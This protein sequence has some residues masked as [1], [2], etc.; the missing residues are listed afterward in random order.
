MPTSAPVSAAGVGE[1]HDHQRHREPVDAEGEEPR[2]GALVR[3]LGADHLEHVRLPVA[4]RALGVAAQVARGPAE[5]LAGVGEQRLPGGERR[6]DASARSAAASACSRISVSSPDSTATVIRSACCG[7][8]LTALTSRSRS[9]PTRV[10][11]DLEQLAGADELLPAGQHLAA[12]QGAVGSR[13]RRPR[14]TPRRRPRRRRRG[15]GPRRRPARRRRRRPGRCDGSA[16][17]SRPRGSGAPPRRGRRRRRPA[18][19]A[20]RGS[21]R[22]GRRAAARRRRPAPS[23]HDEQR[24]VLEP[25][26]G[27]HP[28]QVG[29]DGLRRRPAGVRSSTIATAVERSAAWRRKSHGTWSAYRAAEVTNSHRSAA[30]S[31]WA[32]SARF[33]SSTESTSGASRMARPGRHRVGGHQLERLR[34]VGRGG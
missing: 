8:P 7:L 32:A 18:T 13:P 4:H 9:Q 3:A 25:A 16:C 30:A 19:P 20:S 29:G 24:R 12:Q 15:A 11:S 21:R 34:V 33:C 14:A 31:S 2:R 28:G 5:V 26:A 17:G 27:Q 10:S 1:D 23:V 22:R 6:Q